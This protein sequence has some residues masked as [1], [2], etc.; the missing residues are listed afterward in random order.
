MKAEE[1]EHNGDINSA[2]DFNRQAVKFS[3]IY[4]DT[5]QICSKLGALFVPL[6]SAT[7][8]ISAISRI[9]ANL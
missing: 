3:K 4:L 1:A 6:V 5:Q 2:I 9:T 8:R 7:S